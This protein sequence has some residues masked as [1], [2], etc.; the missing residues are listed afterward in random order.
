MHRAGGVGSSIN[1]GPLISGNL[2]GRMH[3]VHNIA[4]HLIRG[5]DAV[6]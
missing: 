6:H 2:L 5:C 3:T 4:V 1:T